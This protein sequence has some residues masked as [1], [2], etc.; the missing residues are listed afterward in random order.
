VGAAVFR[1]GVER[2]VYNNALLDRG[3]D[4]DRRAA[5]IAAMEGAYAAAGVDHFAAW[6]HEGD[7][8]MRADLAARGYAVEETTRAMA[9]PL[10]AGAPQAA[11][12]DFAPP[13]WSEHLRLVGVPGILAG[14]DPAAF[15]VLVARLGGESVATGLAYDHAGDCGVFNVGTLEHARR[16]GLGTAVTARL[17][18]DAAARGCTTASLQ[19]TPVAERV[20]AALG[21]RDL[22]RYLEL[23]PP[24]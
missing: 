21:F 15:H 9:M 10:D 16:R 2:G 11:A 13:E 1:G 20:Y 23:V 5:A 6:V 18:S 8:A 19:S 4:A 24:A 22:G 7:D 12:I 14:A 17:L 3:L